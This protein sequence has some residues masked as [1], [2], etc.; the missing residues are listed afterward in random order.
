MS[1]LRLEG[2]EILVVEDEPLI[3]FDIML[4]LTDAGAHVIGPIA[5][6][7]E[8]LATIASS[9]P[10]AAILDVR[11]GHH[12]VF[13]AAHALAAKGIPFVFHTGHADAATLSSWANRPAI[14]KPAAPGAMIEAVR[15]L[16]L[17]D[18]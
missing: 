6:L 17:P 12:D 13:P 3:G 15:R 18:A 2:F 9:T 1:G 14:R 8:A 5:N 10:A 4:T 11:P 7:T 16:V